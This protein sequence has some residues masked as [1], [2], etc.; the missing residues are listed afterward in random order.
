M[1]VI[2]DGYNLLKQVFYKVKGKL[3]AQRKH[4][5]KQLGH[6]KSKKGD[7]IKEIIVVFDGGHFRHATREIHSG[8]VV[9]FSGQKSSADQWIAEYVEKHKG[10][11]FLLVSKDRELIS[12]CKKCF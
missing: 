4:F 9:V 5:I 6:Y 10:K 7:G 3:D 2:I 11:E 1:I 12:K 8:I